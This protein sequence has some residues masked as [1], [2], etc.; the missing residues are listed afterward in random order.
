MIKDTNTKHVR[1][2][3]GGMGAELALNGAPFRQPEWSA[4]ALLEAP[5]F[6]TKAHNSY[7]A[8]GAEVIT[9]NSFAVVPYH[10]GLERFNQQ[11]LAL[12]TLS[13]KLARDAV[14]AAGG[15]AQV[16]GSLPPPFGSYRPDLFEP[17]EGKRILSVLVEGL[18]PYI[19]FW[20][21]E[22]QGSIAEVEAV[23]EVLG[24]DPRSLW[25]SYTLAETL[26]NGKSRLRSGQSITSAAQAAM[27]LGAQ[28]LL[29]N[30]SRPE[31]MAPAV[32]EARAA[33]D[34]E[35]GVYANA[36]HE[37]ETDEDANATHGPMREDL[38]PKR[39]L[40]AATEWVSLGAT[41]VGGCCGIGPKHI[42]TLSHFFAEEC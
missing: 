25:V 34:I 21:A 37:G 42:A 19:D 28:A 39:Y 9:T 4:L 35:I 23:R 26:Q 5:N 15:K 12:A 22:T 30:C 41:L 18:K 7:L 2:I 36:F 27:R 13:G 17:V 33:T 10:I 38:G 14:S 8:A 11:G 20:L 32:A 3:D 29:F 16:A 1:V 31:V 24:D 6:V 40:D